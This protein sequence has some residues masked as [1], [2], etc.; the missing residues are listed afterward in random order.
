MEATAWVHLLGADKYEPYNWRVN[1][2]SAN[3]YIGAIFRHLNK[4]R[5]GE[6]IDAESGQ[7][8]LAHIAANCNILMDAQTSGTLDDDRYKKP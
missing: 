1:N 6:D 5:D 8:H 3:T 7:P 2:V 4:W